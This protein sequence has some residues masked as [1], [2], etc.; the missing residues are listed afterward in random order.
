M[1][2]GAVLGAHLCTTARMLP[3]TVPA[4]SCQGLPVGWWGRAVL[5]R[6]R[7]TETPC[8]RAGTPEAPWNSARSST[9]LTL[10]GSQVP[11]MLLFYCPSSTGRGES[12]VNQFLG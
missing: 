12:T 10:P 5:Q 3:H 6:G 7:H 9:V 1:E 8:C 2:S 11:L 4:Q